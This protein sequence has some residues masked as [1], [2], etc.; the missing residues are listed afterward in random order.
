[1][2]VFAVYELESTLL[3]KNP[4]YDLAGFK[5]TS[6]KSAFPNCEVEGDDESESHDSIDTI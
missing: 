1:L 4:N 3:G 6:L 5:Q 2:A